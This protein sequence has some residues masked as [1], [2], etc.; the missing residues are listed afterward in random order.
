VTM[1]RWTATPPASG[2]GIP[3]TFPA[4]SGGTSASTLGLANRGVYQRLLAVPAGGVT[5]TGFVVAIGTSSGNICVATY[6][7]TGTGTGS[8]PGARTATTGSI[9]CPA[10]GSSFVALPV[11]VAPG[12]WVLL[13][14][15]NNT[16]TFTRFGSN[17]D[18][19]LLT[20][21]CHRE[22]VAFPGPANATPAA[23]WGSPY[24]LVGVTA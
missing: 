20:G 22:D 12:D 1:T 16:A 7:G 9:A 15:D 11:T 4:F 3:Y 8:R 21:L 24:A 18:N 5:L 19:I 13:S 10:A 17:A 23:A 14:A 2:I 6:A